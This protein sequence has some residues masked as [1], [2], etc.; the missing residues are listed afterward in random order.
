MRLETR[1]GDP[2]DLAHLAGRTKPIGGGP[3]NASMS[4]IAR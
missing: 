2:R 3:R 1:M 4:T